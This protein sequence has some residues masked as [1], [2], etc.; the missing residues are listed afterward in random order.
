MKKHIA[1]VFACLVVSFVVLDAHVI[2]TPRESAA[3][4]E[5]V[6]TVQCHGG[7]DR[8]RD[9]S[10]AGDSRGHPRDAG[11]QRR[12]S[13]L[14]SEEGRGSDLVHHLEER[15]QAEGARALYIYGAQSPN[16]ARCSGKPIKRSLTAQ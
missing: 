9:R 2:V 3:G 5:Q 11:S 16:Q 1:A 6:Y 7:G 10:R 15:D 12:R 4:A 13:H 8:L 14:R